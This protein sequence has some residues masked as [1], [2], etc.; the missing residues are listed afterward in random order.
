LI[1]AIHLFA[2]LNLPSGFYDSIGRHTTMFPDSQPGFQYELC[3][4][5]GPPL[6]S[7]HSDLLLHTSPQ[8]ASISIRFSA[9]FVSIIPLWGE[10]TD[11][12]SLWTD[13]RS[14]VTTSHWCHMM[15]IFKIPT[16]PNLMSPSWKTIV[17]SILYRVLE[18]ALKN[19]TNNIIQMNF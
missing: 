11:N 19:L 1:K 2:W 9:P 6:K 13:F 3:Q 7:I 4:W 5:S 14:Q 15:K 10:V 18:I 17:C 8:G 16:N 12:M